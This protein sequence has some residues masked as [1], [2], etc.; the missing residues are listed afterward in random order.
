VSS[1]ANIRLSADVGGT[2]T[3]V[4]AFDETTGELRLGKTLTTPERLVTGIENGVEKAGTAFEAARLFLHGTTVAINTI[5]ERSGARCA[6]L[7]TQGFRDIYEIGRVNRPESYNLAF[8]KHRPLIDRDMRFEIMERIDAQGTVLIKLDED[9]VRAA[10]KQAVAQGIEA[11][12]I[13]FLHS[14]RNPTHERRAKELIEREFP[15]LFVT[16]S[17]E[18][19]QEYREYERSSTTAANAYIGPRVRHYLTE[20]EEHLSEAGFG[21]NFLIVQSTGGLFDV[22]DGRSAC[23]RM[24]ESGPAA[25]VIGTKALCESIGMQNAIAFDMG[26]TTA[27]A[28][29]IHQG[30]VLMTGGAL[31][32]GYATGLPI[33]MPMIDIQEVGTGGGSIARVELGN[34]LRVGP[35][36]AGAAPGPVCYGLGGTE[37][38][39]TDANLV[40]GRLGVDR[41]LG[42]EMRLDIEAAKKVLND[43]V[44]KP[45]GLDPVKAA[46]GILRIA[47]TK[48]A[49]VVR[50]VTTE[51]GLDA[52]DFALVAYGGAGPLHASAVARELG[53]ARVV[54]PRAPGHF[55]A[56]GMLVADLR[57]D[58]VNTWFTT[59]ADAP[60]ARMEQI[61]ADMETRGRETVMRRQSVERTNSTR[62]ADMRYVLQ[63]HAVT[64]DLPVELFQ[65]QDRDGIKRR[66]DAVHQTRYG[67][68]VPSERAEIVSLRGAVIGEM[69]KPAF[70][71]IAKGEAKPGAGAGRGSRSVYFASAGF[72]DAP[73]FER[74]AL[75]AGNRIDGPAL[76][77][78]HASTT[79][80]HPGDRLEVDAFGDL[81]IEIRRS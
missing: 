67:F 24:L 49:H 54:I 81:I 23:I 30:E 14:Y 68:S 10:V 2:F 57:R 73:T 25:G 4:A 27:K 44:A 42:G 28:G 11:V 9:Q 55:S 41:F 3:D 15:Q 56:Y 72:V 18:L 77:E 38:T 12:A 69:R 16:A 79:V 45:L 65:Q 6:L 43:K 21:G 62:G 1:A 8:R 47:T 13:L 64:V 66:F 32:G 40:L 51:R 50:W 74:A 36:S 5:L 35:E 31:L 70:E 34:A 58:F 76:I 20:M 29:V 48:M 75:Q 59:L 17:H 39:I 22:E 46:E 52:A 53:I 33:Q 37:P 63:E 60:F 71:P 7:T 26:G 61:F 78:E 80:L 19:S